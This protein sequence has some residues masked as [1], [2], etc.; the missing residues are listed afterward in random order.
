MA[1]NFDEKLVVA[2]SSR[3]LF[4]LDDSHAVFERHGVEAYCAYQIENENTPL[5][6]G[7]AFPLVKCTSSDLI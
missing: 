3:A 2:I 7:T 6:P 1:V 4:N 5:L